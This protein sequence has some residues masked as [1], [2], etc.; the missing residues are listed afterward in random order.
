MHLQVVKWMLRDKVVRG[1][2]LYKCFVRT[3][4]DVDWFF[5]IMNPLLVVWQYTEYKITWCFLAH[6]A[7]STR[8][9]IKAR[10][11]VSI[12]QVSALHW[13][14]PIGRNS[15]VGRFEYN[16]NNKNNNNNKT[17]NN[18]LRVFFWHPEGSCLWKSTTSGSAPSSK[19]DSLE[20][21]GNDLYKRRFGQ[22]CPSSVSVFLR[23]KKDRLIRKDCNPVSSILYTTICWNGYYSGYA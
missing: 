10:L 15:S 17:N 11:C 5:L 8:D 13:W 6:K 20:P 3:S 23:R 12:S 19:H 1:T 21:H 4:L 16:N 18:N 22:T 14:G 7:G 2:F 9:G